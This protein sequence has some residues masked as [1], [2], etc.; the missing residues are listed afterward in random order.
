DALTVVS[1]EAN[2]QNAPGVKKANSEL[3]SVGLGVMNLHGYL[4]KN[5]I[6]YESEEAKDFANIFF[7]MMNYYSI[8]RSMQIAKER[9]EKYLDFDKSDYANGKYFEFYTSQEFEPQF[10]K[11]RELFKGF[12]IPT[13]EDWKAL[14]KD[15]EQYGLYHAYRLAIAP[16]QSISYVQNATSSVMP[17]VDQI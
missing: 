1:D 9:G 17:I 8:E 15:V 5:K 16:T 3:H 12:E 14:Q 7:M 13:A 10:E 2:I 4:A 6:G 11:V